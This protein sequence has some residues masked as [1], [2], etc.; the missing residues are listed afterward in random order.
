MN[1][2]DRRASA[3]RRRRLWGRGAAFVLR[4]VS[5]LEELGEAGAELLAALE[6]LGLELEL[7]PPGKNDM[8]P[9]KDPIEG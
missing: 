9:K 4:G 6:L 7:V 5:S 3:S 8:G 1:R 2:R